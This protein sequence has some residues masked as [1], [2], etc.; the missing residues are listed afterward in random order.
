MA[1]AATSTE[2]TRSPPHH[3]YPTPLQ[4][5]RC[6][7]GTQINISERLDAPYLHLL[8]PEPPPDDPEAAAKSAEDARLFFN[9]LTLALDI[10]DWRLTPVFPDDDVDME[11]LP[12][13][14]K[15]V[16]D[17]IKESE[18]SGLSEQETEE[19]VEEDEGEDEDGSEYESEEEGDLPPSPSS[20][21]SEPGPPHTRYRVVRSTTL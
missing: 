14:L 21:H 2:Q 16:F 12:R 19:E 20:V 3:N 7:A 18:Q 5:P 1:V 11:R 15:L 8:M 9:Y 13:R 6:T 10:W 17:A 4:S